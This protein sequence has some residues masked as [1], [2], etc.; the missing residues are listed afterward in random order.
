MVNRFTYSSIYWTPILVLITILLS[1]CF[2]GYS[3][4]LSKYR[5]HSIDVNGIQ[6]DYFIYVPE[7]KSGYFDLPLVLNFH[8][9]GLSAQDQIERSDM[10]ALAQKEHFIVVYPQGSYLNGKDIGALVPI[11]GLVVQKISPSL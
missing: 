1:T 4:S 2:T 7:T 6:R 10:S 9:Y 5:S 8:G 11:H 3:Q